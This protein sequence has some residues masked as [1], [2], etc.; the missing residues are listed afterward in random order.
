MGNGKHWFP[1]SAVGNLSVNGRPTGYRHITD[2]RPTVLSRPKMDWKQTQNFSSR[3][4][5]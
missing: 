1:C 3:N 5:K 2:S 4:S